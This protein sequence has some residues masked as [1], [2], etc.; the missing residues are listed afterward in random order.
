MLEIDTS[1]IV[2]FLIVWI[3]V[4]VLTKLFFDPLRKIMGLR[5]TQL[6]ER[7][8]AAREASEWFEKT[9]LRIEQ[10]LREARAKAQITRENLENEGLKE[11]ERM[12]EEVNKECRRKVEEAKKKLDKQIKEMKKELAS[13]SEHLAVQI[14]KRLLN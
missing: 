3:L 2:V 14:E 6:E 10:Q 11:K 9:S 4:A 12:L 5:E 7:K 13:R 8:K 1:L